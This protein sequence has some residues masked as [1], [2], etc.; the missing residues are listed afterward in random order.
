MIELET[1]D[2]YDFISDLHLWS[3]PWQQ[4]FTTLKR[5]IPWISDLH[6][7]KFSMTTS[8][9]NFETYSTLNI[10]LIV[11]IY[12]ISNLLNKK[13]FVDYLIWGQLMHS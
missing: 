6:F 1:D 11:L 7:L 5:K 4:L 8:I 2:K 12:I 3:V 9:Y 13:T 10:R